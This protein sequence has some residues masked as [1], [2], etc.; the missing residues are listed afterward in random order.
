L[1]SEATS[2]F[3]VQS[4]TFDVRCSGLLEVRHSSFKR[5]L[6]Y[7][8]ATCECLQITLAFIAQSSNFHLQSIRR[9]E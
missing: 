9:N 1:Q 8:N 7:L 3:D 6:Y 2:L 5:A 4:W